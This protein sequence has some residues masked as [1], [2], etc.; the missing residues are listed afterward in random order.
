MLPVW[1]MKKVAWMIAET[2]RQKFDAVIAVT[3]ARGLGK[4][5]LAWKLCKGVGRYNKIGFKPKRDIVF[6]RDDVINHLSKKKL[7][8]IFGDEFVNVTYNRDFS[9]KAQQNFLKMLNMYRDSR[10]FLVA[11]IPDFPIL[12]KQFR[13]LIKMRLQV[14]RRGVAIVHLQ[15]KTS[16]SIDP[17]DMK[18]NEKVEANWNKG[19]RKPNYSQL[20][21]SEGL[22]FFGDLGAKERRLYELIKQS[23]RQHLVEKEQVPTDVKKMDIYDKVLVKLE[24][25]KTTKE[26]IERMAYFHDLKIKAFREILNN[27]LKEKRL[28]ILSKMLVT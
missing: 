13:S 9:N 3:G 8:I 14:I 25:G 19:K 22:L 24:D 11:C 6:S 2:Q 12:D 4:S 28:P 17:W 27:R 21:T 15:R 16:Y 5:T 7:G 20:S 26:D 18:G 10:N 1:S 23:K